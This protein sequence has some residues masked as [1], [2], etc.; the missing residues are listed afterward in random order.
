MSDEPKESLLKQEMGTEYAEWLTRAKQEVLIVCRMGKI[1]ENS[2]GFEWDDKTY[3]Q[4]MEK[5]ATDD[6]PMPR[7]WPGAILKALNIDSGD[8]AQYYPAVFGAK[9]VSKLLNR[10]FFSIELVSYAASSHPLEGRGVTPI[11]FILC[12]PPRAGRELFTAIDTGVISP[13][14]LYDLYDS[15]YPPKIQPHYGRPYDRPR[16]QELA[17]AATISVFSA[18]QIIEGPPDPTATIKLPT[19][20]AENPKLKTIPV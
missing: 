14:A 15:Y 17:K 10:S 5:P 3:G 7:P 11:S 1:K 18:D 8:H 16:F 9:I 4:G 20:I 13:G 12:F 19:Y 6:Y 2:G